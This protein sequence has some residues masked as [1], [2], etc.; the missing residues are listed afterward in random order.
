MSPD[1]QMSHFHG[2]L[3]NLQHS[4]HI[5]WEIRTGNFVTARVLSRVYS[6][7]YESKAG[8]TGPYCAKPVLD[9][10]PGRKCREDGRRRLQM[11]RPVRPTGRPIFVTTHN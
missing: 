9:G 11:G 10:L 1:L 5:A 8:L 7:N 2:F 6:G 4:P 3:R